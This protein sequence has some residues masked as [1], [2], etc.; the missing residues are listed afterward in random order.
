LRSAANTGGV[1]SV[2]VPRRQAAPK[3]LSISIIP[4]APHSPWAGQTTPHGYL[5]K[6]LSIDPNH[7]EAWQTRGQLY[8]DHIKLPDEG[9]RS[10]VKAIELAPEDPGIISPQPAAC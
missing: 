10:Y 6:A 1:L 4:G 5:D 2:I 8:A 3:T 9:L 7:L